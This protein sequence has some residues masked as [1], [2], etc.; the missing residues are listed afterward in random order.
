VLALTQGK[1]N[2][3]KFVANCQHFHEV[4]HMREGKTKLRKK[5]EIE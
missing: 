5:D 4:A 3:I 2:K 1:K